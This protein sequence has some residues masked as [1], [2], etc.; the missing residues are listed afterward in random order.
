M[1]RLHLLLAGCLGAVLFGCA[2]PSSGVMVNTAGYHVIKLNRDG[3][4]PAADMPS[5]A[6]RTPV[7]PLTP[8]ANEAARQA[9]ADPRA[10]FMLDQ[11]GVAEARGDWSSA[12]QLLVPLSRQGNPEAQYQ[13][14]LMEASGKAVG[15][16]NVTAASICYRRAA[17]QGL[18]KAQ[19]LLG[20]SLKYGLGPN[21]AVYAQAMMWFRKAADQGNADAEYNLGLMYYEGQGGISQDYRESMKWLQQSAAQGNPKAF[22]G[23]GLLYETALG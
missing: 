8:E 4:V 10:P 22:I 7:C 19:N 12:F 14:G 9:G 1:A 18:A 17:E 11:A 3:S 2:P 15:R 13:V 20:A 16:S 21:P 6:A 23:M 5:A